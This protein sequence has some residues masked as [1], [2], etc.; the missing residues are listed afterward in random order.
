[1]QKNS[2][3]LA[4][5][6]LS[7][8]IA[9]LAL[10][11]ASAGVSAQSKSPEP[12]Q[13]SLSAEATT[14]V[15]TDE[16]TVNMAYEMDGATAATLNAGVLRQLNEALAVAKKVP[17]VQARLNS[18]QTNPNWGPNGKRTGWK[19]RGDIVLQSKDIPALSTLTGKLSESLQLTGVSYG[20]SR[21]RQAEVRRGLINDAAAAF[22]DKAQT[23]AKALG[24]S[25]YTLGM[26][27]LADGAQHQPPMP[28]FK[29]RVEA[30]AMSADSVALPTEGGTQHLSVTFSG[31]VFLH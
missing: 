29:G 3:L 13:L 8:G 22:K 21:E 9:A 11:T 28:M 18:V 2:S 10:V 20:I 14:Q 7:L 19:V 16:L 4:G 1:M 5:R 30:V 17:G 26:V 31:N 24:Y 23:T 27:N 25:G 15:A 12:P 6:R